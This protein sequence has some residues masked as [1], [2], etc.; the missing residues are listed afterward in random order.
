[1]TKLDISIKWQS[2]A[3]TFIIYYKTPLESN[4]IDFCGLISNVLYISKVRLQHDDRQYWWYHDAIYGLVNK[5]AYNP[6]LFTP[7]AKWK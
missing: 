4:L 6:A 2:T 5:Q 3:K 1:M 7:V